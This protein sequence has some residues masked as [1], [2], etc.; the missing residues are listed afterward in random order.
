I[1]AFIFPDGFLSAFGFAGLAATIWAAIIP[2]LMAKA[3][4]QRHQA[5]SF[6]APGGMFMIGFVILFGVINAGAHILA[7][8]NLLPIYR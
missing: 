3:S 7:N 8:F 2:A 1:L 4:R 5:Q 6:K